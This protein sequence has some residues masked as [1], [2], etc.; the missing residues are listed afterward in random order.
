MDLS[1]LKGILKDKPE[2]FP[3]IPQDL[4]GKLNKIYPERSPG[5]GDSLPEI[6]FK[7]GARDV[8]RRLNSIYKEQTGKEIW[9]QY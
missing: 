5:V 4:L 8:I 7:A 6:Y 3:M 9:E 2:E 1:H